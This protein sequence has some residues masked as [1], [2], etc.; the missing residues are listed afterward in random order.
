MDT[1]LSVRPTQLIST[2]HNSGAGGCWWPWQ[3]GDGTGSSSTEQ[4]HNKKTFDHRPTT[5]RPARTKLQRDVVGVAWFI[6]KI[7]SPKFTHSR[8]RR[9][10]Q[11]AV[12]G[13]KCGKERVEKE[14][15]NLTSQVQ[16][17]TVTAQTG[18]AVRGNGDPGAALCP[19]CSLLPKHELKAK[20]SIYRIN[21]P[22]HTDCSAC[23]L[24]CSSLNKQR[25][26]KAHFLLTAT[27]TT[28]INTIFFVCEFILCDGHETSTWSWK[29]SG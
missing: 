17:L 8:R 25:M 6:C 5:T 21:R 19:P 10:R 12:S 20:Y 18:W 11:G 15:R 4:E 2:T 29:A 22:A 26:L 7:S 14:Q 9:R 23:S 27:E 13:R 24:Q 16:S 3:G 28:D 1:Y